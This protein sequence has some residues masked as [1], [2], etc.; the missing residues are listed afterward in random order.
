MVDIEGTGSDI[1]QPGVMQSLAEFDLATE[2]VG[3]RGHQRSSRW[4]PQE[5]EVELEL[6]WTYLHFLCFTTKR[7]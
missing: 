4:G 6:K 2:D 5:P 3:V 7:M 1:S